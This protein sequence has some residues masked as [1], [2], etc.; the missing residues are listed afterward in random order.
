MTCNDNACSELK[1]LRVCFLIRRLNLGGAQRQLLE[2][3]RG[4]DRTRFSVTVVTFYEGGF[5][6]QQLMQ[7]SGVDYICL[8]KKGRWEVLSFL[9]RAIRTVRAIRPEIVYSFM[10]GANILAAV[11]KP[12][13][14]Q[15]RVVWGV[16]GSAVEAGRYDWAA[17][18]TMALE[19][20]LSRVPQ[21]IIANSRAGAAAAA[22]SGFPPARLAVVPNGIDCQLFHP[23]QEAGQ[24]VRREW[25][26]TSCEKV[27]GLVGR[28]DPMKDHA[29]FLR[30]GRMLLEHQADLRLVMVGAGDAE[31]PAEL[32]CLASELGLVNS[33]LW[34]G[35]RE[36]MGAVYN[37]FD[38]MVSS[39]A[40]GEGFPNVVGE[41]MACGVPCV[42]TDVGDSAWVVGDAGEV[43]PPKD[44]AALAAAVSRV[45]LELEG[46]SDLRERA[47]S[48]IMS[49][50][51][52]SQL[53]AGT[54]KILLGKGSPEK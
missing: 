26:L 44:P 6:C 2:L 39:S 20:L 38:V 49:E 8:N 30:A 16:R 18:L 5:F 52:S 27:V 28:P 3:V 36:D 40:F 34:V 12:F 51:G 11:T 23:Q 25:G 45:L 46:P 4:M 31:R 33:C 35:A 53:V 22:A 19:T 17:R 41:A 42:V 15:S 50:F 10:G 24:R 14:G 13:L 43:V 1:P 48:R 54:L 9:L 29:N 21:V 32:L 7:L 47:R 37:A